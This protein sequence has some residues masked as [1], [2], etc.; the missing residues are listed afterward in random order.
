M[1][2]FSQVFICANMCICGAIFLRELPGPRARFFLGDLFFLTRNPYR[3]YRRNGCC[4]FF[5][6]CKVQLVIGYAG[7]FYGKFHAKR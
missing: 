2:R 4:C 5:H 7:L 1:H 6:L 3:Y